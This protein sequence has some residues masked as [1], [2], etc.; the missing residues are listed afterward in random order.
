MWAALQQ[1]LGIPGNSTRAR[2]SLRNGLYGASEYVVMPI[3]LLLATPFLLHRLGSAQ[4]GL[5]MVANAAITSSG[6]I[7]TGFGDGALKYAAAYRG[8]NDGNRVRETLR[9]NLT[10]NL[11]LGTILALVMWY[12]SPAAAHLLSLPS[13]LQRS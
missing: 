9:V 8:S 11:A 2:S 5:W 6:F 7:S 12:S 3:T 4:F 13:S 1:K 10:I